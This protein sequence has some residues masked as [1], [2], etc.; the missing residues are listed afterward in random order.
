MEKMVMPVFDCTF[1]NTHVTCWSPYFGEG[2]E[3]PLLEYY[4]KFN[5]ADMELAYKYRVIDINDIDFLLNEIY[6]SFGSRNYALDAFTY[7]HIFKLV[8]EK[9]NVVP[10][11]LP[12]RA[13]VWYLKQEFIPLCALAFNGQFFYSELVTTLFDVL[14]ELHDTW[15]PLLSAERIESMSKIYQGE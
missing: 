8:M 11:S 14:K 13:W 6:P 2:S 10:E 4:E 12:T 15:E 3:P 9:L 7:F 1:F 5:L